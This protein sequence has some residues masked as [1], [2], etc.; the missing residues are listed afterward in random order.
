MEQMFFLKRMIVWWWKYYYNDYAGNVISFTSSEK[1][2]KID[3]EK[4]S[5]NNNSMNY[6]I[7]WEIKLY[8]IV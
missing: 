5:K 3:F 6:L 2:L 1:K 4:K 7:S 8:I